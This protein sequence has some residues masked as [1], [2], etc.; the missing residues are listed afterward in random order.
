MQAAALRTMAVTKILNVSIDL[1]LNTP[2]FAASVDHLCVPIVM[3][4]K[5]LRAG[6]SNS[7]LVQHLIFALKQSVPAL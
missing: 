1:E 7:V 3:L 5:R 4:C 6:R 2:T